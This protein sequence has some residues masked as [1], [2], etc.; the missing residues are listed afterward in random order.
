MVGKF[1]VFRTYSAGVHCGEL[2]EINGTAAIVENARRIWEW[3]EAF[4]LNEVSQNG[5]GEASRI[6]D[7]VP[8]ILLTQT[9]EVIPCSPKAKK[10][11]S[12]SRNG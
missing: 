1:C 7:P 5:V 4:T 11:L 2:R 3:T 8:E 10:N 6:S 12:R 9:I